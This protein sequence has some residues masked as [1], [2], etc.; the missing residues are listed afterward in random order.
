[1]PK[2]SL[3]QEQPP[4]AAAAP[5]HQL[6]CL[7]PAVFA[8]FPGSPARKC[9]IVAAINTT[10]EGSWFTSATFVSAGGAE[11]TRWGGGSR[12]RLGNL[13]KLGNR[14]AGELFLG[15]SGRL[16]GEEKSQTDGSGKRNL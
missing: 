1:M 11:F 2:R 13:G 10:A 5:C 9:R 16:Q 3:L 6:P 12:D 15:G 4:R 8:E 14:A 7:A